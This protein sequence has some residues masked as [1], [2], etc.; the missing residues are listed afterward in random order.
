MNKYKQ[1]ISKQ[2]TREKLLIILV[3]N[4]GSNLEAYTGPVFTLFYIVKNG[5]NFDPSYVKP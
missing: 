3:G 4:G 2:I 5:T 1:D